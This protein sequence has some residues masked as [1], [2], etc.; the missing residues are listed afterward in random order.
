MIG[1][2]IAAAIAGITALKKNRD[3]EIAQQYAVND[4]E[5]QLWDQRNA[6]MQ[7]KY[8]RMNGVDP[9]AGAFGSA[10]KQLHERAGS[11][12]VPQDWTPLVSAVGKGASAVYKEGQRD[13]SG[14]VSDAIEAPKQDIG[15]TVDDA[16]ASYDAHAAG[17]GR[18]G[19]MSDEDLL[20]AWQP[21]GYDDPAADDPANRR[22]RYR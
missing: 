14:E 7:A 2:I 16:L 22:R 6:E 19:G 3:N 4:A 11:T 8:D 20:S 9:R 21:I 10:L 1:E 13:R 18:G 17:A 12:P 15:S 5:K